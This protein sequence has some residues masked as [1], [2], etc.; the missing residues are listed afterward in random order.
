[1]VP[2][3][4]TNTGPRALTI[5]PLPNYM[6]KVRKGPHLVPSNRYV[7][8]Y[9]FSCA[10]TSIINLSLSE[11]SFMSHVESALVSPL[12]KKLIPNKDSISNYRPVSNLSFISKLLKSVVANQLN[13]HI[14]SA[15]TSNQCQ[16]AYRKF[17]STGA[18]LLKIHKD[19]LVSMDAGKVTALTLPD[20]SAISDAID[21]TILLR[22]LDEWF[23][24]TG[25]ALDWF[26]YY[27]IEGYQRI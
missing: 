5:F 12:L 24:V 13:S 21:H 6:C 8:Q 9:L 18:V 4:K 2:G 20:V 19:I 1:M 23:G 11:G 17:H 3:V 10:I 25:K 22:R 7:N 26:K 14:N 27:L 15:N 16:S